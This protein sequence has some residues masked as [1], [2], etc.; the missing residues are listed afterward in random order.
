M[1]KIM[2]L[3]L[4]F[5][6]TAC[7]LGRGNAELSRNESKWQDAQV[8]HYRFQLGV[9]CFCPVGD[10]MPMSVEVQDGEIVSITDVTGAAFEASDPLNELVMKYATIDRIFTELQSAEVRDADKLTA[11]Y[12]PTYG[13]PTEVSIDFVEQAT[14]DELYLSILTFE[15]LN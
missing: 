12:D 13:F 11:T 3:L 14:D 9:S 5:I 1:N 15:P 2:L 8:T 6:L 7:S 4:T 10:R